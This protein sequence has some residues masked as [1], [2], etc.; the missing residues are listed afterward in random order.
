MKKW[1]VLRCGFCGCVLFFSYAVNRT[2]SDTIIIMKLHIVLSLTSFS[3]YTTDA[4]VNPHQTEWDDMLLVFRIFSWF[5]GFATIDFHDIFEWIILVCARCLYHNRNYMVDGLQI[6]AMDLAPSSSLSSSLS[7]LECVMN[8]G[9]I[10]LLYQNANKPKVIQY[11]IKIWKF[12]IKNC[13]A[14]TNFINFL[15]KIAS[16]EW[17]RRAKWNQCNQWSQPFKWETNG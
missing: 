3:M 9:T 14:K 6:L 2:F 4:V 10:E 13:S 12:L 5:F 8:R 16:S 11:S 7:L 1:M 15:I 17:I